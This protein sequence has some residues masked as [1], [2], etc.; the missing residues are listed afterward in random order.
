MSAPQDGGP[1]RF[2]IGANADR[3][4][5]FVDAAGSLAELRDAL[6]CGAVSLAP[7]A[8]VP[9]EPA[10]RLW[11]ALEWR[12]HRQLCGFGEIEA[13]VASG[14][15]E[16]QVKAFGMLTKKWAVEMEEVQRQVA[17][18]FRNGD[19]EAV[20]DALE[21][22]ADVEKDWGEGEV[23]GRLAERLLS[24]DVRAVPSDMTFDFGRGPVRARRHVNPDGS[25]GGWVAATAK[26]DPGAYVGRDAR[27]FG[28]ASVRAPARILDSARIFGEAEVYGEATVGGRAEVSDNGRVYGNARVLG[29]A[30]VTG[31]ACVHGR[32]RV[33]GDAIC[34][35]FSTV[36]GRS[37]VCG[38]AAVL[39]SSVVTRDAVVGGSTTLDGATVGGKVTLLEGSHSGRM[40]TTE[41]EEGQSA[42]S[43]LR[44]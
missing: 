8:D 23:V 15:E 22:L 25:E 10:E 32:A 17:D 36:C 13:Y 4:W 20:V 41:Y 3:A 6:G 26:V 7:D 14:D 16:G 38:M 44:P 19:P 31:Y 39:G 28:T 1:V 24:I 11:S 33:S 5:L 42:G 43:G 29:N 30:R 21:E 18:A 12:G 34:A 35:D 37:E 27:V 40:V 2:W 9:V